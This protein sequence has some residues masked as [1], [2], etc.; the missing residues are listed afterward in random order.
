MS[1]PVKQSIPINFAGGLDTKTD[2]FQV[3][4]A[5]FLALNN[6]VFTVGGRLTKRNGFAGLGTSINQTTLQFSN[7][8]ANLTSAKKIF[9]YQDELCVNDG[10]NLYSYDQ[11]NNSWAYKGRSTIVGLSSANIAQ[12]VNSKANMDCSVDT[13]SGIKVFAW[14]EPD[15]LPI[16]RYSI[17]DTATGQF[18]I[19]KATYGVT[20]KTPRCVSLNG[21]SYILAVNTVDNKI[22]FQKIVG[23]TVTGVPTALIADP[24]ATHQFYDIEFISGNVYFTYFTGAATI[25]IQQLNSSLGIVNSITKAEDA[26]RGLSLFGDGTNIW[27]VYNNTAATKAFI[28]NNAVTATVL[29][30]TIVDAGA[31]A[32]NVVNV[33]GTWSSTLN[34]AFIFYDNTSKVIN[35]N[36]LTVGG[37][38]GTPLEFMRSVNLVSKAFSVSG[39][40]HVAAIF[41]SSIQQTY[42]LLNCYNLTALAGLPFGD[43]AANIA[44]KIAPHAAGIDNPS[45]YLCGWSN[46]GSVYEM[47]LGQKTNISS[48]TSATEVFSSVG[49]IDVQYDFALSNP[50]AQVLGSCANIASGELIMYDAANVVEQNFHVYP[51]IISAVSAAVGGAMG[52]A[53]Q[54]TL[55]SWIATYEWFDNQGQL[56]RSFT[57][58]ISTIVNGTSAGLPYTFLSGVTTGRATIVIPTLRV[59]NKSGVVIKLYRTIGSG[60][61]YFLINTAFSDNANDPTIDSITIIDG[62]S[63]DS[64]IGN[65]Q[66]Y[67]TGELADFAP[68]AA[69][70]LTTFK[71]RLLLIPAEGGYDFFYSKQVLVGFPIEFVPSFSVNVGTVA[72]PL[73]ALAGMDDKI[74]LFKS[75]LISGPSILY[76]VGTGPAAS[77]ANND[78]TDPLP[79]AV[80]V[81]CVD[82]A[83]IVLT[84]NGLIFKSDKG[85][86]QLDRSLQASYIGAPVESFNSFSVVSSQLIPNTTQ[87]RFF[88][89]NGTLLMYDYFYKTWGTFSNPAGISD[90]IFQG[91][92]TYVGA[93]GQVYKE[94]P[95]VYVDGTNTPI[96]MN[97]T[98]SWIKLA[99]LQGYQ[100][101]YFFF[102]L[103]EFISAHQLQLQIAYNFSATPSQTTIITPDATSALENWRVFLAQ[104]RCQ[105]FQ[106]A[107][108]EIDTG[109][110]G[111]A[112][113][114]SGLNLIAGVKSQFR[115]ISSAQSVG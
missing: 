93:N 109:T 49:V 14:E 76:M 77:G 35:F 13:T 16:V 33:T 89:S 105:S 4:P 108:Q 26:S 41:Q 102:L 64:I 69:A 67:T 75:G 114:L 83:S 112:F 43:V 82:R 85:I 46:V 28:V 19:N 7:V 73:I 17:Q 44:A 5:N 24:N 111:A 2:P 80:D 31:K 101:S 91:E 65:L 15:A 20:Y 107:L 40:A 97:F 63:D 87:V 81:G 70:A 98:T 29:A 3:G 10:F 104:Q 90:C 79:V 84:P 55:Y 68:P 60:S 22:Y 99:G 48:P 51:E 59:T 88:L 25:K 95:G 39:I 103:A 32:L 53:T 110:T 72:G 18:I 57:S 115:T 71:N 56:H 9:A 23:Q 34:K 113:T 1:V 66:L 21:T 50:D 78:F 30:P 100:R 8:G 45:G 52:S 54:D 27:V 38:A 36:T 12:D 58:P 86:Y 61:V 106:I 92:H 47:A 62:N 37:V 94:T 96:L 42:F 74:I 6:M 11:S